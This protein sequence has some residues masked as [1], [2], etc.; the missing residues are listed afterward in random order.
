MK[1]ENKNAMMLVYEISKLFDETI[2]KHPENI[3][4]NEKTSRLILMILSSNDGISQSELVKATHMKGST[5]S[6]AISKMEDMGYI[7]RENNPYDMRSVKV[8]LTEKGRQLNGRI[9]EIINVEEA[10]IMSGISPK[11]LRI[12]LLVLETML[13]NLKNKK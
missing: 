4:A 7:V 13:D 1:M 6:V 12:T 2:S 10:N 3:F 11:E 9:K 5:V 8:Y